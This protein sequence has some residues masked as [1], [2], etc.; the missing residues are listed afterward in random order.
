MKL[1]F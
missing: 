1:C